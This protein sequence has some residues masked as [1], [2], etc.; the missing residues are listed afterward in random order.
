[1]KTTTRKWIQA[2]ISPIVTVM[3]AFM[4]GAVLIVVSGKSPVEAYGALLKGGLA[5]TRS[6]FNTLFSAT[7]IILTGLA[8][9]ISFKANIF[10]MGVEGQLY[11]GAF[12][13]AYVGFSFEG[14]YPILHV[15]LCVLAAMAAGGIYA[16]IPGILK[17]YLNVNEMVSTIMLNYVAILF[18]THLSSFTFKA[19]GAGFAATE[20][21]SHS[22]FLPRFSKIS[23]LNAA[24][25]LAL[26]FVVLTFILMRRVK[27]GYEIEAI[28]QNLE[29]AEAAGMNVAKKTVIIMV[30]S[31]MIGGLAGAGEVLGVHHRFISQFSPGY[32]WDGMTIALLG[33]NSPFGVLISGLF[34]GLLKNG[35]STMELMVEVPR[36]L[37]N[38]LQ[39]L[40]IFFLAVELGFSRLGLWKKI[41]LGKTGKVEGV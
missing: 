4:V 39:G 27:L 28:G 6:I 19:K 29:F 37:I 14:L 12:A 31:G 3:L 21:I 16:L 10:N 36:S 38:I 25:L 24:F 41:R 11:M 30:I 1:M 35:G 40:I 22:A 18:T 9:A 26:L 7:P 33:K 8:T 32:G 13:A 23:Q 5:G 34:F 20:L 2:V 17:G 15:T